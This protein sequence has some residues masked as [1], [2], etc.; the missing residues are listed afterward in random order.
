V[1]RRPIADGGSPTGECA[2]AAWHWP[3]PLTRVISRRSTVATARASDRWVLR[4][5]CVRA[6]PGYGEPTWRARGRRRAWVRPDS[7]TV[8]HSPFQNEFSPNFQTK[9]LQTLNTKVAQQVTLYKNAKGSRVFAHGFEHKLQSKSAKISA[10]VNSNPAHC[11]AFFT[12]LH[13]KLAMP[14]N[15][16]VVCLVKLHI[17]PIGW[18]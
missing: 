2:Q 13:S 15:R 14:L 10:L 18:F 16:K 4:R 9:V 5:L 8:S 3:K 12:N 1:H 7:N 17:F 6:R 11:F